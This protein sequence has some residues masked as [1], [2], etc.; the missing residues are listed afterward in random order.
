MRVL[1]VVLLISACAGTTYRAERSSFRLAETSEETV[2]TSELTI[3]AQDSFQAIYEANRDLCGLSCPVTRFAVLISNTNNAFT[4]GVGQ[5]VLTTELFNRSHNQ[6]EVALTIAH[7]WAHGVLGHA[8]GLRG[9]TRQRAELEADCVGG[10]ALRRAGL[11]LPTAA[12]SFERL[13][14]EYDKAGL[15][16]TRDY[17][18]LT[19]RLFQFERLA[20]VPLPITKQ[21]IEKVCFVKF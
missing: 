6:E 18:T 11:D 21:A 19:N 12:L 1:L 3:L 5:V 16:P 10:L 13:Q 9:P 14:V 7:E 8:V 15:R 4:D 2:K 17:P 20:D